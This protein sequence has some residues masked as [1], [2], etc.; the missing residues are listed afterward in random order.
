MALSTSNHRTH[1]SQPNPQINWNLEN[2]C[3]KTNLISVRNIGTSYPFLDWF[4]RYTRFLT[5]PLLLQWRHN[6]CDG[7]SNH[8]PDACLLNHLFRRR[9]K[10]LSVTGLCEGNSPATGEFPAQRASDAEN[11]PIWLC[12]HVGLGYHV[13]VTCTDLN[14]YDKTRLITFDRTYLRLY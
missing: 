3:Y 4:V 8:R 10:K 2:V 6:E 1:G 7:V 14:L 9:S 5:N 13:P 12:H 11:V